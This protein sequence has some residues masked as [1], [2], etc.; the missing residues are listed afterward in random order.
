MLIRGLDQQAH[1]ARRCARAC[2]PPV[3]R[4]ISFGRER[5]VR[6]HGRMRKFAPLPSGNPLGMPLKVY[7]NRPPSGIDRCCLHLFADIHPLGAG[8]LSKPTRR[9]S[10][11]CVG[12]ASR[13]YDL[14]E[15]P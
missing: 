12:R 13:G 4:F 6:P 15:T 5:E 3:G 2:S 8:E 7:R 1:P 9:D 14:S 10:D 11:G